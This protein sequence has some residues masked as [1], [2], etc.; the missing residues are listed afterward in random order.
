MSSCCPLHIIIQWIPGILNIPGNNLVDRAAKQETELPPTADLLITF[1]KCTERHQKNHQR[2]CYWPQP[3]KGNLQPLPSFNRR[4]ADYYMGIR[5]AN[6][7]ITLRTSPCIASLL[8]SIRS[9]YWFCLS[10][11]QRRRSH[12]TS[13][14]DKMPRWWL[15]TTKSIWLS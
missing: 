15:L 8:T 11:M 7:K 10:N 2:P 12:P 6:S 3:N 9:W 5:S 14:A 1:F 13:L 4:C